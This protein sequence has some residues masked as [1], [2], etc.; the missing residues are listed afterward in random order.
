MPVLAQLSDAQLAEGFTHLLSARPSVAGFVQRAAVEGFARLQ[1][2]RAA[3]PLAVVTEPQ[4]Y[5]HCRAER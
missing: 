1:L 2:R 5:I 3:W 4:V